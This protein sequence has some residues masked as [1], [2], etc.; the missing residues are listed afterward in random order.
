MGPA[1][2]QAGLSWQRNAT[3]TEH[4]AV[5]ILAICREEGNVPNTRGG[6]SSACPLPPTGFSKILPYHNTFCICVSVFQDIL[7]PNFRINVCLAVYY[8]GTSANPLFSFMLALFTSEIDRKTFCLEH[9]KT[10]R[11]K[12][13]FFLVSTHRPFG[14]PICSSLHPCQDS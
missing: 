8:K 11:Y 13:F 7:F 12:F 14:R 3:S 6:I 10:D 5:P 1:G 2:S 4:N 9:L